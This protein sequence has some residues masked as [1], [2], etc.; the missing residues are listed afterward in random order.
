MRCGQQVQCSRG[1]DVGRQPSNGELNGK[2]SIYEKIQLS[3]QQ[4]EAVQRT[5]GAAL[6]LAVPG[7]GKTTTLVARVGYMILERGIRPEE[8]LV[9]TFTR[10]AA[11][12]MRQRFAALFGSD[13]A[14]RVDFQTINSFCY[15]VVCYTAHVSGHPKPEDETERPAILRKLYASMVPEAFTGENEIRE[16]D[17]EITYIKNMGL[18]EEEIAE[19]RLSKDIVSVQRIYDAYQQYLKDHHKM[20]YDDQILYAHTILQ[21]AAPIREHFQ[22]RYPY[23]CVDE[24]QDTSKMQHE[25]IRL[26]AAKHGNLFMV[27]D[28]DQSIYGFRAAY[29]KALLDYPKDWPGGPVMYLE[30]H[31]RSARAIVG[32]ADRFI[33]GNSKRY[34]KKMT[35]A[36]KE[37]GGAEVV[38]IRHRTQQYDWLCRHLAGD[39]QTAVLYR[40][41]DSAVPVVYHLQ[42]AGIPFVRKGEPFLFF[43]HRIVAD[44]CRIMQ[45]ALHP[46][47]RGLFWNLYY[48]FSIRI[49]KKAAYKAMH[50]PAEG[51]A[52]PILYALET[53]SLLG[54]SKQQE[55][56][57]LRLQFQAMREQNR[58]QDAIE[59]IRTCMHY[60]DAE[61]DKLLLLQCLA[62][63]E[64]TIEDFLE[65]LPAIERMVC[66]TPPVHREQAPVILSTMHAC[67]GLE[68]PRVILIDA[69]DGTLPAEDADMEEERRIYYVGMT[70]ARD[71]LLMLQYQDAACPFPAA[72]RR[73]EGGFDPGSRIRHARFG[74]GV[75]VS[76][77]GTT[78]VAAFERSGRRVNLNLAY[79]LEKGLLRPLA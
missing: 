1:V 26:L 7:S 6:L 45:F 10:N 42:R 30:T 22:A 46:R 37:K 77:D 78:I 70:R 32:L 24:A 49:T 14:A 35:A 65:R 31:Y 12:D 38:L 60:R 15:R 33:Q 56:T 75:I 16:L 66:K 20:D 74:E 52:D 53:S 21:K 27:G 13:L 50:A 18:T 59:A 71:E 76:N 48:K 54:R 73:I 41:N 61:S 79:C 25:V 11:E 29:P 23:L 58:A 43:Q 28:E 8:I 44:A 72:C 63:P 17:T 69:V 39:A 51:A 9:I 57:S 4:Q 40:N 36:R 19:R 2:L 34:P 3:Q 67:K 5:D 47:D 62:K 64:E 55:V 68:Y